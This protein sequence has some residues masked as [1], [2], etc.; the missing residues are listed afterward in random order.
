MKRLFLF[1]LLLICGP[2]FAQPV[3]S[4]WC[5]T[6]AGEA[7][8]TVQVLLATPGGGYVFAGKISVPATRGDVWLVRIDD[9][10]DTLWTRRY[11]GAYDDHCNAM[12]AVA[13]GGWILG[14]F[15]KS[16]GYSYF[17]GD[18][19]LL[20]IDES[21]DTLWTR[22]YG[23]IGLDE[24]FGVKEQSDGGFFVVAKGD[25]IAWRLLRLDSNGDSV[26][27]Q[28]LA[29]PST[30]QLDDLE[31]T[32]DGGYLLGG[33]TANG[34]SFSDAWLMKTDALGDSLWSR[35]YGVPL[36][37][38]T[39]NDVTVTTDGYVFTGQT[40]RESGQRTDVWLVKID[41][42]GDTLWTQTYGGTSGEVGAA[43]CSAPGGGFAIAATRGSSWEQH[44]D[45][46][47]IRTDNS[48][49]SLWSATFDSPSYEYCVAL[50]AAPDGGYVL[51]GDY[52]TYSILDTAW[53]LKT[54]SD[55]ADAQEIAPIPASMALN[56]YPNPF[57]STITLQF[58]LAHPSPVSLA[59]Y[60]VT[61]RLLQAFADRMYSAGNHT[62]EWDAA[63]L[64]SGIYF[65]HLS[66]P[67]FT[68]TQKL[69]HLK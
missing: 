68:A 6:Y 56:A 42:N 66:A 5:H 65:V 54:T 14:G 15:T 48:G 69:M 62:V 25:T 47:L 10:G 28:P 34:G 12:A 40:V 53:L 33:A 41:L 32:A 23:D 13:D 17:G 8:V 38:Q 44:S 11:G 27:S 1:F 3:D 24:C 67:G 55:P 20:R 49:D 22:R 2:V 31:R 58:S 29:V 61:G 36:L 39:C 7:P 35:T 16:F 57:N 37:S 18:I 19:W 51:A 50:V 60:N 52:L 63:R 9:N 46:W 21:G 30:I 43:I 64:P 45:A 59:M 26:S 4:V